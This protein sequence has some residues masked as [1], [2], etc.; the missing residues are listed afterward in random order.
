MAL[1]LDTPLQ[2][3]K[4]V[5]PKRALGLAQAE[6]HTVADLLY[7]F[8]RRYLDRSKVTP[9]GQLQPGSE[10]T[11]MGEIRAAGILKG[12]K[13]RFEATL[14]DGTG[15]MQL[16][17]FHSPRRF[18]H[19]LKKGVLLACTGVPQVYYELQM[20]HPELEILD[21]LDGM[22]DTHAGRI[23]PIYPGTGELA[24]QGIDSRTFRRLI[25]PLLNTDLPEQVADPLP[26][27]MLSAHDLL[28]TP[29]ALR[30]IHYPESEARAEEARRRFAFDEL[31]SLQVH[32]AHRRSGVAKEIKAHQYLPPG[33]P[34]RQLLESLPF[35]LTGDQKR[36]IGEIIADMCARH[37]MQRLLQGDV[38]AGK[39]VVAAFAL[40]LAV[41]S[42]LQAAI[43]APTEILAEQ[44][45]ATL[46]RILQ[47]AGVKP[48]LLSG[49]LP[50]AE[51]RT[52]LAGLADGSIGVVVGTHAL[53]QK[54]VRF[55]QLALAVVDEQHRFGVNQRA[56]LAAKGQA[57]DLLVMT[58]TPI[59]RTLQLLLFGDLDGS[60]LRE[61]PP[62]RT[63]VTTRIVGEE[64]QDRL[65]LWL[66][67]RMD[68]GDQAYIVY[69]LIEESEKQDLK[70]AT[71]EY[72]RLA[73]FVFPSRRLAL[74]HGRTPVEERRTTM[75]AFREGHI[76]LLVAT[77]VI[78][79]GV[80]IPNANIMVIEHAER[81]GLSQL[82]QL[83]GRIRRGTKRAF[84]VAI[85]R[86]SGQTNA[87]ERLAIFA[88]TDDG[89]QIAEADLTMRGPGELLGA[90]Q[91]G[92]PVL[93]VA[94]L[95]DDADLLEIARQ[96]ATRIL[97]QDPQL[98]APRWTPLRASLAR[99]KML[100]SA[101]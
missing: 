44:H 100:W 31:F 68:K 41:R 32:L 76:D 46:G 67:D 88:G 63:P 55:K 22:P 29:V 90:R 45:L 3:L 23:V 98:S 30:Q 78:E 84:C 82:H 28:S 86:G 42:G 77:T 14:D 7:Y 4:G 71:A 24:A 92:L 61:L 81:F 12:R 50:A 94:R 62:G 75:A 37:P 34:E 79:I 36:A 27:E 1:A 99:R 70:A 40:Y 51:K 87:G 56:L 52:V 80:D 58:A 83:R 2:F 16:V 54:S 13:P 11:V 97:A 69:P 72:A 49:A 26:A 8:P 10:T 65:W 57:T 43:M 95:A 93:G 9:V 47:P 74:V 19:L 53:I 17:F 89:F 21:S 5:G 15:R 25:A 59:P 38:G 6:L 20:V 39:T 101:G 33:P 85:A 64:E 91:H 96:E 48:V 66:A 60:T 18:V 73:R 35:E